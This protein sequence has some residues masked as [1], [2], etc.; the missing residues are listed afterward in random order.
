MIK[1]VGI[2]G[3]GKMGLPMAR[4]MRAKGF[5]V[6]GFDL[7]R[8]RM[9]MAAELGIRV[10]ASPREVAAA[11]DL[12]IIIVGFDSEVMQVLNGENGIFAGA[13][14]GTVI[15][16]A[17]TCYEETMHV[18]AAEAAKQNKAL[19]V[20]DMPLCRAERAAEEG[21][22]LLLGGG[23]QALFDRCRPVFSSFCT[24]IEVLGGLGA[25]QVGKM[26]NNLLL[27][28]CISANYEGLKLGAAL[29]L[30]TERLRQ[31][32]L[33]S[34]GRNWALETWNT[35]RAMPWAEKDMTIVAHE[36]DRFRMSLPLSGVV[37]E[38]IKAI[39]V[40]KGFATPVSTEAKTK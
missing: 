3:L 12:V 25:G 4:H 7:S 17:S 40:E 29:G 26:I 10:C 24:D 5:E 23:E 8:E 22:L 30:D 13:R 20:L 36:A 15:A 34:S 19:A 11:S 32:L 16:V 2:I 1:E 21:T 31:A 14:K 39:K 38:V 6:A 37:K 18:I 9:G 35:H 28:A 27:W 33:K